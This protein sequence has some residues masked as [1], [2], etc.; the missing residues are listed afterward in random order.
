[1]L[2]ANL[3]IVPKYRQ[4]ARRGLNCLP[5]ANDLDMLPFNIMHRIL[6]GLLNVLIIE[7]LTQLNVIFHI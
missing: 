2:F 5:I 7:Y 6:L 1:M 4:M 3:M